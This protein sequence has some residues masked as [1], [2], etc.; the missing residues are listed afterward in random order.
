MIP[1]GWVHF[2]LGK[3]K[4]ELTQKK[5]MTKSLSKKNSFLLFLWLFLLN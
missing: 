3:K 1:S 2:I 4:E 5:L